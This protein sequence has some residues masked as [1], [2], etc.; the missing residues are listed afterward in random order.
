MHEVEVK[1]GEIDSLGLAG[2]GVAHQFHDRLVVALV[3]GHVGA[4]DHDVALVDTGP[5]GIDRLAGIGGVEHGA[6]VIVRDGRGCNPDGARP[7]GETVDRRGVD[8]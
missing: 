8:V 1:V 4:V 5:H 3:D 7:F 2:A 6:A